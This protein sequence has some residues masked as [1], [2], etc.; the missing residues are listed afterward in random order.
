MERSA[1]V[2]WSGTLK[3]G[4]GFISTQSHVLEKVGYGFSTRFEGKP[5]TN[6]EELIAAAHASC[7]AMALTVALQEIGFIP[8]SIHT[9]ARVTL[10]KEGPVYRI[11]ASHLC[12]EAVVPGL[13]T[14]QFTPIAE[15]AK[16]ECPVS[17]LMDAQ[18]SL[19]A[20]ILTNERQY[21]LASP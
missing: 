7:Y 5:G 16:R 15:H 9:E 6:P 14:A 4:Q 3:E 1:D 8:K 19:E 10:L 21:P 17:K 12:V 20:K 18:V 2:Q 11:S 13:D